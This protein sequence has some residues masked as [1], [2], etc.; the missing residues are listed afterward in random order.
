MTAAAL[1]YVMTPKHK[2][3]DRKGEKD[4]S[5]RMYLGAEEKYFFVSKTTHPIPA[6]F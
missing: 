2:K 5:F 3:M 6:Y 4:R 1:D